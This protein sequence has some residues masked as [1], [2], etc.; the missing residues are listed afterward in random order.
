MDI[1]RKLRAWP[2]PPISLSG[3]LAASL[4]PLDRLFDLTLQRTLDELVEDLSRIMKRLRFAQLRDI[5]EHPTTWDEWFSIFVAWAQLCFLPGDYANFE[6]KLRIFAL[7]VEADFAFNAHAPVK[8]A[9]LL[10]F[11]LGN[12]SPVGVREWYCPLQQWRSSYD[13]SRYSLCLCTVLRLPPGSLEDLDDDLDSIESHS[14]GIEWP[15]EPLVS[16]LIIE[17][18]AT[19]CPFALVTDDTKMLFLDLGPDR[20]PR[21]IRRYCSYQVVRCSDVSLPYALAAVMNRLSPSLRENAPVVYGAS[22]HPTALP[23]NQT[24]LGFRDFDYYQL[25][26]SEHAYGEFLRCKTV[27]CASALSALPVIGSALPI[28]RCD[29]VSIGHSGRFQPLRSNDPIWPLSK[30]TEQRILTQRRARN[31]GLAQSLRNGELLVFKISAIKQ[32]GRGF[33]SQVFFGTI[34][35]QA[36][37]VVARENVCLKLFDERLSRVP[38]WEKYDDP[39]TTWGHGSKVIH[40]ADMMLRREESAYERLKEYQGGILPWSYG[41]HEFMMPDGHR[42][43][44]MLLEVIQGTP[45][46]D[47]IP[48][49]RSTWSF[50][51]RVELLKRIRHIVKVMTHAGVYQNDWHLNQI[52]CIEG[53]EHRLGQDDNPLRGRAAALDIVLIDFTF[54]TQVWGCE[55]GA[56]LPENED[57]RFSGFMFLNR[58]MKAELKA[59]GWEERDEDCEA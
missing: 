25:G 53:A 16:S 56:L 29:V 45:L 41:F 33:W 48:E 39:E 23:Y 27:A 57:I 51:E 35:T 5:S 38:D 2:S 26:Q 49:I 13:A 40:F 15:F 59:A 43:L 31:E 37:V 22:N 28:I 55:P 1:F 34:A 47:R 18:E 4:L 7:D 44:G 11:V 30:E 24:A 32:Q 54:A 8:D 42:V 12:D 3:A 6:A 50:D 21:P 58:G 17:C 46:G 14:P 52:L 20:P 9:V 36:G 10:R 19:L